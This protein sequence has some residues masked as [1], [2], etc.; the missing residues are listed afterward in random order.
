MILAALAV[1]D[2]DVDVAATV[3]ADDVI[4]ITAMVQDGN[5]IGSF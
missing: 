5:I 2:A 1:I 4:K 3:D